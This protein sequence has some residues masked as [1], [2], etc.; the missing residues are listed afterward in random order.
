MQG[1][2][3]G[4]SESSKA[5][6]IARRTRGANL[7]R[8]TNSNG[9]YGRPRLKQHTVT[10]LA[11]LS[12]PDGNGRVGAQTDGVSSRRTGCWGDGETFD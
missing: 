2:P 12:G 4:E 3:G 6:L 9:R 1:R 10:G 7:G 5:W 8:G 11:G